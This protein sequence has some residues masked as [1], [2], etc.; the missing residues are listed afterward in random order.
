MIKK[1][2]DFRQTTIPAALLQAEVTREEMAAEQHL[3]AARFTAISAVEA[4]IENGDVVA[5][6]FADEKQP[7]GVRRVYVNVGKGFDEME[8]RLLGLCAGAAVQM[9]YAG[10]TV[11]AKIVSVKRLCVPALNAGTV[12]IMVPVS[13]IFTIVVGRIM[14]K[15]GML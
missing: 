4:P 6:E 14:Y 12:G 1:L 7:N 10:K 8:E 9:Q 3:A 15:K 13:A 11:E 2:Y 5:L